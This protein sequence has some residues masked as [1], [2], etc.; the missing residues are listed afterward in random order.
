MTAAIED[1]IKES[2][3]PALRK[4]TRDL[5]DI[6]KDLLDG[7]DSREKVVGWLQELIV[8]TLGEVDDEWYRKLA[9]QFRGDL[10]EERTL[11]ACL[12]TDEQRSRETISEDHARQVRERLIT[13]RIHPAHHRAF[14]KLRKDAGEYI[15][16]EGRLSK[17]APELQRYVAMRPALD[18]LER[19]QRDVLDQLLDGLESRMEILLTWGPK[20]EEATHGEVSG[21]FVSRC[22]RE[23]STASL[24]TE[25]SETASRGRQ[26]FAVYHLLPTFN[27]GV[28]DLSGRAGEQPHD[29]SEDSEAPDW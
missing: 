3:R 16:T 11:L 9:R 22:Y 14:R 23:P 1:D 2:T 18:E 19:E 25:Q 20:L 8:R 5:E 24:L 17:H 21:A 28:R 27:A 26:V 29:D 6:E 7:F 15:D 10:A 12:L 4:L 13:T